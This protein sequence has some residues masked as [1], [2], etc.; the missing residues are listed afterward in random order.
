MNEGYIYIEKLEKD[1]YSWLYIFEETCEENYY[2]GYGDLCISNRQS[3]YVKHLQ[4]ALGFRGD[5]ADGYFGEKTEREVIAFQE[6]C[7]L[8]KDGIVGE[9]TKFALINDWGG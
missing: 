7:G 8:I 1:K 2:F 3:L 5:E 6:R 4:E 9:K